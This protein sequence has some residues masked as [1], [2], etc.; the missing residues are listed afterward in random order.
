M[1]K[2]EECQ[3]LYIKRLEQDNTELRHELSREKLELEILLKKYKAADDCCTEREIR[4][5]SHNRETN[6][7]KLYIKR[8]VE[9]LE[10]IRDDDQLRGFQCQDIAREALEKKGVEVGK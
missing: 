5:L 1:T 9:A 3:A 8:L 2:L 6:K 4:I 7:I 10:K